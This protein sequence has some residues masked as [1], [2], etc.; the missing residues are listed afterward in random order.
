MPYLPSLL[1]KLIGQL[2]LS[3]FLILIIITQIM[4]IQFILLLSCIMQPLLIP[5]LL[6]LRHPDPLY[7][8]MDLLLPHLFLQ[9]II[10]LFPFLLHLNLPIQPL[11]E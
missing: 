1:Q 11:H 10:I 2:H 3:R 9:L 5:L 6:H 7:L 8:I 4:M